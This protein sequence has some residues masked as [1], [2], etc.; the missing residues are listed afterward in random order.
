MLGFIMQK[1]CVLFITDIQSQYIQYEIRGNIENVNKV[2]QGK[3]KLKNK[4][5]LSTVRLSFNN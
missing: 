1:Y 5:F 2:L 4:R 3:T